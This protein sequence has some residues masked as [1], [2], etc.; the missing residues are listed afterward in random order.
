MLLLDNWMLQ[1]KMFSYLYCT[2]PVCTYLG[3]RISEFSAVYLGIPSNLSR[4]DFFK[5]NYSD[6]FI[7]II[8][9]LITEILNSYRNCC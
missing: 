1:Y 3:L 9:L 5:S 6:I 2:F 4:N 8:S 7:K